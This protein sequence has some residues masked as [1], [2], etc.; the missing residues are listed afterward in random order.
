MRRYFLFLSFLFMYL[1]VAAQQNTILGSTRSED[2]VYCIYLNKISSYNTIIVK[3]GDIVKIKTAKEQQ[4]KKYKVISIS[5]T[6]LE[7][8]PTLELR[9]DE[10]YAIKKPNRKN[11]IIGSVF[12]AF[13]LG[14]LVS[15]AP[16][17]LTEEEH[18][19]FKVFFGQV[20]IVTGIIIMT[21]PVFNKKKK[22]S[23]EFIREL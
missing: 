7:F 11:G 22:A 8:S 23:I 6:L 16:Y 9:P 4:F 1:S 15:G 21:P 14:L 2:S 12:L 3:A 5:P 13:G 19:D 17:A 10:I 18:P 20:L